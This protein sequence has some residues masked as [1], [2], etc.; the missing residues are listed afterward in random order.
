MVSLET[1]LQ[2][3]GHVQI[4]F[5]IDLVQN[6]IQSALSAQNILEAIEDIRFVKESGV[7]QKDS[8][9]VECLFLCHQC[10]ATTCSTTACRHQCLVWC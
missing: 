6:G 5:L 7:L 4:L 9:Y 3:E 10:A 8:L 2:N 1:E